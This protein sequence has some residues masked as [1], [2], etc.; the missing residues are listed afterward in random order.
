[1][2]ELR[3]F[4]T[5][6]VIGAGTM[7]GGIAQK[8][9][10]EGFPVVLLDLDEDKVLRG[11]E[12]I[13]KTLGEGIERG[14]FKP[15]QAER[16]LSR[17]KGTTDWTALADVDLAVEAV[18]EDQGVKERVFERLEQVCR[19]DAVLA[20]NTSS[21]SVTDLAA[22]LEHPERVVGLHFFFHPAKNRLVEVVPGARTD[23]E[24][25]RRTWALQEQTGKIPIA[26]ADSY[27]FIV[28]RYFAVWLN[29]AIRCAQEGRA[30][31]RTIEE[32]AKEAFRV[33]MG[34]FE[35]M[36]VSGIPIAMH[37][38]NT[39]D[40]AYGPFYGPAELLV[41]QIESG[42]L[43][44]LTGEPDRAQFQAVAGR[45]LGGV[46]LAAAE[47][48]DEGVGTIDDVDLGAR[49]G[50]R[51]P[52]GPFELANGIGTDVALE[53]ARRIAETWNRA[54]PRTLAEPAKTARPFEFVLVQSAVADG[55]ATLTL[56]R[57]DSLNALNEAVMAQLIDAFHAAVKD[58]LVRGIVIAGRG[59]AFI[60]GADIKFFI[61]NIDDQRLDRT[62]EFTKLGH[63][64]LRAIDDCPKP[65]VARLHGLALGG[66]FELALACDHI[67]ASE[68]AAVAFP[69]T[70][71]GIYP[72]LGGTQRT[73]RR[74]GVGLAKYLVFTGQMLSA[75][76]AAEIG[77]V[78]RVVAPDALDAAVLEAID[79]GIVTDRKPAPVPEAFA[80]RDAFFATAQPDMLL[81]NSADEP[82]DPDLRDAVK[83]VRR[84]APIA[85]RI[86]GALIERGADLP[87]ADALAL[88]LDHLT[89]I[90]STR[91]AY[92]GLR[93]IGGPPPEFEGR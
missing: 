90:F 67:I 23:A 34:P 39:L 75:K 62:V 79:K 37:T 50:L 18:F 42:K 43:W 69:E 48:V 61:R 65:V 91:D 33:G 5:L 55:V 17:V 40:R 12:G 27:G 72:G 70:G 32:A 82:D 87:I 14:I 26:S 16:I 85:L 28:N 68:K 57:P 10:T 56:N 53:I 22:R 64:F 77:L 81:A 86:A 38:C 45:M 80:A 47:L 8:F 93:S 19:P 59:K 13:R 46:L 21:F 2:T 29:E 25:L 63:D 49:V 78:D 15:E 41:Q 58:P 4:E 30:S 88:E 36:N 92:T 31:L 52:N 84:K 11:V 66:G 71:I 74:V 24:V 83:R 35:L 6:A 20:T 3:A 9:A 51:W 89:E 44:D 1:M 73:T 76:D 54:L 7:G 60:A